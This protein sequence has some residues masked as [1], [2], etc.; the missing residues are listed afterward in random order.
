[1]ANYSNIDEIIVTD[2]NQLLGYDKQNNHFVLD[3]SPITTETAL[4]YWVNQG[5]A[6]PFK[7]IL[8]D[9]IDSLVQLVDSKKAA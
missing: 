7:E 9:H 1:M 8:K 4:R 3:G 2:D 5:I 6:E